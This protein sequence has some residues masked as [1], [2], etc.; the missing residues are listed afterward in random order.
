VSGLNKY[1]TIGREGDPGVGA[2]WP[3]FANH[4]QN[5]PTGYTQF[6]PKSDGRWYEKRGSVTKAFA[7][8]SDVVTD[9]G[10]LTGLGDD[11]HTIY[12]L[13]TGLREWSEQ[14]SD[15]ST[16]ASTKWKLYFKSGG[17]Y[18]IDDAGAV[19]GPLAASTIADDSVKVSKLYPYADEFNVA[20]PLQGISNT[21]MV[22][23]WNT[24]VSGTG[25]AVTFEIEAPGHF[26]VVRLGT[27]TT[28]TG[29]A[30]FFSRSLLVGLFGSDQTFEISVYFKIEALSS[31]AQEYTLWLGFFDN[32]GAGE[33]VD[34]ACVK[35]KRTTSTSWLRRTSSNSTATENVSG[36]TTGSAVTV[37]TGW[38]TI[39]VRG[40]STSISF[41]H[42]PQGGA[43]VFLGS[44]STNIPS[45]AGRV[46]GFGVKIEKSAGTTASTIDADTVKLGAR[47]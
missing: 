14:G 8:T 26:G 21:G 33:P 31:A 12:L 41:Y 37:A 18:Y 1:F 23:E 19:I 47:P 5:T 13:A 20:D 45:G 42:K 6:Y 24:D 25:A 3:A 39:L 4:L 27:G 22:L 46:F 38:Q 36:T 28:T 11:D 44:E 16:P 17:L 34:C 15:P 43:E 40:N 10:A 7:F 29:R 32:S 2:F 35:Y 9:H 30:C